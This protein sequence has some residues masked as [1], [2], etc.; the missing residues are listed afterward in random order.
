MEPALEAKAELRIARPP[1]EVFEAIVDP[2]KMSR[3]F[4]SSGS[5]R[6]ETGKSVEWTW[7]DVGARMTIKSGEVV[8][9]Q[10]ISFRWP[11]TG[12]ETSVEIRLEPSAEN[13]TL[14]KVV[15]RG[16]NP[17]AAGIASYA[18]QIGGWVHMLLCL[19]AFLEHG[20]NLRG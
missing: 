12:A 8:S 5:G 15:E 20:I 3:Y 17:D 7:A 16:W 19:K 6:L 4:I 2:E 11:A 13:A 10:R 14:V 18:Q 9:P 1:T